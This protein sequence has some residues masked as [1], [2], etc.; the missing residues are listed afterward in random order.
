MTLRGVDQG[1]IWSRVISTSGN[2]SEI[3]AEA[4]LQDWRCILEAT[5]RLDDQGPK[6][7]AWHR[8]SE[9]AQGSS[10]L[11]RKKSSSFR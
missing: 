4:Q 5:V 3:I 2:D 11:L 1:V 10:R 9:P 8:Y 6:V 7:L